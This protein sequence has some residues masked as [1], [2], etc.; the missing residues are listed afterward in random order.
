MYS[1]QC[2]AV[3]C[4]STRLPAWLVPVIAELFY[5]STA[6]PSS[7]RLPRHLERSSFVASRVLRFL[8]LR[9]RTLHSDPKSALPHATVRVGLRCRPAGRL[10]IEAATSIKR[11]LT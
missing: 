8:E 3:G 4:S 2:R 11:G 7:H 1:L 10:G 9:R 6:S 5:K